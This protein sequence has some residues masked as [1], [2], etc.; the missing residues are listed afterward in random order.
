MMAVTTSHLM[1]DLAI[2]ISCGAI[3][4]FGGTMRTTIPVGMIIGLGASLFM[5]Y[6]GIE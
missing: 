2:G 5:R 3:V 4:M 6:F 1:M